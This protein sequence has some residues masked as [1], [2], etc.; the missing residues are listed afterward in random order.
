M[1]LKW[2]NISLAVLL[3]FLLC[4]YFLRLFYYCIDTKV[5]TCKTTIPYIYSPEENTF[6]SRLTPNLTTNDQC[7]FLCLIGVFI[8]FIRVFDLNGWADIIPY[9]GK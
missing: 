6:Y 8:D 2:I 3:S 9:N 5:I 1:C 4:A 7:N